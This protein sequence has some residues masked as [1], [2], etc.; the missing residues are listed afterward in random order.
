[1]KPGLLQLHLSISQI[2]LKSQ[3]STKVIIKAYA[4]ISDNCEHDIQKS[5]T[6]ICKLI[7][8]MDIAT[9]F[10]HGQQSIFR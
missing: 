5:N 4:H 10:K 3:H 1:M 8:L 6:Q 7:D 2:L 9:T